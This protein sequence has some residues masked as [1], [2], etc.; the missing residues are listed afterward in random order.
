M[1]LIPIVLLNV[2]LLM[3]LVLLSCDKSTNSN[4][5]GDPWTEYFPS[6][7]VTHWRY[8]GWHRDY[9]GRITD[10]DWEWELIDSSDGNTYLKA[11]GLGPPVPPLRGGLLTSK[12]VIEPT[13]DFYY[14]IVAFSSG[15]VQLGNAMLIDY[16]HV[17]SEVEYN[18]LYAFR[19]GPFRTSFPITPIKLPSYTIG[20]YTHEDVLQ[21]QTTDFTY[22]WYSNTY[23]INTYEW[24]AADIGL[25]KI[26]DDKS[27]W[28]GL[29]TSAEHL[30]IE[31]DSYW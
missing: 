27:T 16:D 3:T 24:Y 9:L 28:N 8:V 2:L 6:E 12:K 20:E 23:T 31:L 25:I 18:G 30:Q 4:N 13:D 17:Q 7:G 11:E 22:N 14:Y 29:T 5:N 15:D 1:K 19:R 26:E 21:I 10:I